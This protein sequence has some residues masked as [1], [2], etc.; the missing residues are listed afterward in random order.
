MPRVIACLKALRSLYGRTPANDFGPLKL[1]AIQRH[2]VDQ[3]KS[4]HYVNH[5]VQAIRRIFRWG[6]S[7]ELLPITV[8]QGLATVQ[9]IK[10]THEWAWLSCKSLYNL[11]RLLTGPNHGVRLDWLRSAI[12]ELV[13]G[14]AAH[15]EGRLDYSGFCGLHDTPIEALGQV[16]ASYHE[17]TFDVLF[18][19]LQDIQYALDP[20]GEC[21]FHGSESNPEEVLT[22]VFA[23][24]R[25]TRARVRSIA[26][27]FWSAVPIARSKSEID[28]EFSRLRAGLILECNRALQAAGIARAKGDPPKTPPAT[29]WTFAPGKAAYNGVEFQ[30]NGVEAAFLRRFAEAS[31]PLKYADL[32]ELCS[33]DLAEDV[34]IRA[35]VAKL[36]KTIRKAFNLERHDPLPLVAKGAS[37]GAWELKVQDLPIVAQKQ[38]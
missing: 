26:K 13:R 27:A 24:D 30:V 17:V 36:R 28:R 2:L 22:Q 4:R 14:L 7:Q 38:R 37:Q 5:L 20:R 31:R 34:T 32:K 6:A 23:H 3:G 29:G 10:A 25:V 33:D 11:G 18:G 8:Y 15:E 35:H 9:G 1:Q 16:H 19:V 12:R 21:G